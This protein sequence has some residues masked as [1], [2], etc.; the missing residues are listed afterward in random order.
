MLVMYVV[1]MLAKHPI[2]PLYSPTPATPL[3]GGVRKLRLEWC[4]DLVD[5]TAVDLLRDEYEEAEVDK[6]DEEERERR[7]DSE[8][9]TK[10]LWGM[11]YWLI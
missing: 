4:S 1:W 11:Y 6:A 10:W 7:M 5:C 9:W 8:K 3:L 2:S